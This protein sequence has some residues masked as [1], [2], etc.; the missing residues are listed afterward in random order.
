MDVERGSSAGRLA[1]GSCKLVAAFVQ[2][3]GKHEEVASA[4]S[5]LGDLQVVCKKTPKPL[6]VVGSLSSFSK[7]VQYSGQNPKVHFFVGGVR[8]LKYSSLIWGGGRISTRVYVCI[9]GCKG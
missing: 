9:A 6:K 1:D 7:R 2:A 5:E 8:N 4:C 3:A